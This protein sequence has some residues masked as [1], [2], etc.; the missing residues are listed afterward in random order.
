MN[1][2]TLSGLIVPNTG[3]LYTDY[4]AFTDQVARYPVEMEKPY[5]ALGI[6]DETCDELQRAATP[7]DIVLE[8]GDGNWYAARLAQ[9]F[10]MPYADIVAAAKVLYRHDGRSLDAL[11]AD[12]SKIAGKIAGRVKKFIR[13]SATWDETTLLQFHLTLR[14]Y[15]TSYVLTSMYAADRLWVP[16]AIKG[17]DD[18]LRENVKKL[19]GRWTRGTLQGEG[20]HR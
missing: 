13:D 7:F 5:L 19:G 16:A 18:I 12:L 9:A 11:R 17:F 10:D 6:C 1:A 20:D 2:D 8:L 15:I 4:L 14:D 3:N